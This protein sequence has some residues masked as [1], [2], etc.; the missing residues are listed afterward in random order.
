MPSLVGALRHVNQGRS[1]AKCAR[2]GSVGGTEKERS[3]AREL[4]TAGTREMDLDHRARGRA[5]GTNKERK[6]REHAPAA[7]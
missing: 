6:R 1:P 4:A 2:K 5:P 3:R 7:R